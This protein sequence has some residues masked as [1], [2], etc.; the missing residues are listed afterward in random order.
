MVPPHS[1]RTPWVHGNPGARNIVGLVKCVKW[2][3]HL[4]LPHPTIP[5]REERERERASEERETVEIKKE[6]S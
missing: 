2:S 4:T 1:L 3:D 6:T 5:E